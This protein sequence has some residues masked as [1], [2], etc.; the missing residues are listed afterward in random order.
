M[1]TNN[2]LLSAKRKT[3][4]FLFMA[5]VGTIC[6]FDNPV[7]ADSQTPY[8]IEK[9][10]L[11]NTSKG[12]GVIP[13][14]RI[15]GLTK[16]SDGRL[17]ATA[18][19]LVCGTDPGFGQVDIVCRTSDDNGHTW[20]AIK[21]VA[22]GN[23]LTSATE[24]FFE[25][26]FGDPA[27]VADRTSPEALILAVA[28]CTLYSS[29]HTNR[30][31]PQHIALIRSHDSGDTW[32]APVNITNSIYRLF[33]DGYPI[34]AAFVGGGRIFQSRIVKKGDYYRL[35]AALCARPNGN[36]VIYSD[37]F[38]HTWQALGGAMSLPA[39][40]GDEPKCDE[41]PDGRVLLSSR[42]Q[43]GRIFNIFTYTDTFMGEGT[44]DEPTK[45]TLIGAGLALGHNST[46]G[47][48]LILPVVR[49]R[50]RQEMYLAL[51]SIPTGDTREKVS[52]FYK[53]LCDATDLQ[54]TQYFAIGWNGYCQISDTTS[55]YSSMEWQADDRIG[56]LWEETLT[57][58]GKRPNPISTSFPNG[59]GTHNFDGFD[60]LYAAFTVEYLTQGRYRLEKSVDRGAFL[61]HYFT[62]LLQTAPLSDKVK[63]ELYQR[64]AKL[65][66]DPSIKETDILHRLVNDCGV[67]D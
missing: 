8:M 60:N 52:I 63:T 24:N 9:Q 50:D 59:E 38:G 65:S 29:P 11:F 27:V 36:R 28:G 6:S 21:E 10:D 49:N 22:V 47:E 18:A 16:A 48:L 19:R 20:S 51:Q 25:T 56:F 17:I 33:D 61:R 67:S 43:G 37:D 23:G 40:D 64:I 34:D 55:A 12:D 35:Y 62:D 32:D 1:N 14:Y 30:Q 7:F 3:I 15:P 42:T 5:S 57:G 44:W 4:C 41:L 46:N 58:F 13:P 54:N 39:P 53:E 2:L 31:N 45:S 26:A 66:P